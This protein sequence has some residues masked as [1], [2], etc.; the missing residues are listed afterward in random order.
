[1]KTDAEWMTVALEE[2]RAAGAAGDVPVGCVIVSGEQ[3]IGRGRN[4]REQDRD[5]TAH[6]EVVALREA[7]RALGMWRVE[8]TLYVTQEPC[9][10]CAGALA[11]AWLATRTA[12]DLLRPI[13]GAVLLA[14]AILLVVRPGRMLTPPS[15]PRPPGPLAYRHWF[16]AE[17][18]RQTRG[19]PPTPWSEHVEAAAEPA[20]ADADEPVVT[21]VRVAAELPEGWHVSRA[22]GTA[23]LSVVGGLDLVTAPALRDVL[24]ELMVDTPRVT[25][26]LSECDFLDSVGLSV[27]LAAIARAQEQGATVARR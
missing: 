26:D 20:T 8:A 14:W 17:F 21:P 6:A 11:G 13:I 7:A 19:L 5:P 23:R 25:V 4:R 1:M 2:A 9:P 16:L 18:E 27:L 24:I 12:D 15:E 3:L 22:E 10:M